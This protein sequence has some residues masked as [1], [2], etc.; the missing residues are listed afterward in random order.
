MKRDLNRFA[1][2]AVL[3]V[4]FAFVLFAVFGALLTLINTRWA[5]V[6]AWRL[7]GRAATS[8]RKPAELRGR[9]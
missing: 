5:Q 9:P 2:D 7:S 6:R 3:I 8:L 1:A 4:H